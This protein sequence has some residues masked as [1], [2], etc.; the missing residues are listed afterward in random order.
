MATQQIVKLDKLK[1]I[2]CTLLLSPLASE[3]VNSSP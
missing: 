3:K 2:I 1:Y